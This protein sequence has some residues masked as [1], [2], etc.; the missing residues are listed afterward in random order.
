[1]NNL[2]VTLLGGAAVAALVAAPATAKSAH[3]WTMQHVSAMHAGQVKN[4]TKLHNNGAT[5]VTSYASAFSYQPANAPKKTELLGTFYKYNNS[6]DLCSVPAKTTIKAPKKSVYA[7]IRTGTITYYEGCS[8]AQPT[9]YGDYWSNKS[10][11]SGNTDTFTSVLKAHFTNSGS[12]YKGT[13]NLAVNVFI[14]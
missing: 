4:K 3:I 12:K 7:Q 10:G 8:G 9:F 11:K 5:S 1:M 6:G 2:T 14:E 13:L